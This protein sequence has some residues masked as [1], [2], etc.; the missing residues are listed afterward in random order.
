ML[1]KQWLYFDRIETLLENHKSTGKW[2]KIEEEIAKIWLPEFEKE[3]KTTW[4]WNPVGS[5]DANEDVVFLA[6]CLARSFQFIKRKRISFPLCY[7]PTNGSRHW[8]SGTRKREEKTERLLN[9]MFE[10]R[11]EQK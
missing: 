11:H 9:T 10:R 2:V 5:S 4:Y 6:N 8:G 3:G 7:L 1:S